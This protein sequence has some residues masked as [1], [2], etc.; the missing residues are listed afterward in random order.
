MSIFLSINCCDRL[1]LSNSECLI[2]CVNE[3]NSLGVLV[4]ECDL[5]INSCEQRD[6][7]V[8]GRAYKL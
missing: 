5:F 8:F 4:V 2:I 7:I 1:N 6:M 3:I